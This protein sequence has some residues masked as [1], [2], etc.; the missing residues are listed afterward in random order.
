[1]VP[2]GFAAPNAALNSSINRG[3]ALSKKLGLL[4][5]IVTSM[6]VNPVGMNMPLVSIPNAE[7]LGVGPADLIHLL[8]QCVGG[9]DNLPEVA[10]IEQLIA[11]GAFGALIALCGGLF[12]AMSAVQ[13]EGRALPALANL[14]AVSP[15][16]KAA[17]S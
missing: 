2:Q 15:A 4:G 5:I 6:E 3:N 12:P 1:M 13:T 7:A 14:P 8:F 17:L 10:V 16:L 11:R 9:G